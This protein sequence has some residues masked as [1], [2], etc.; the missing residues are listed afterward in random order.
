MGRQLD[1]GAGMTF[2]VQPI[3]MRSE[4]SIRPQ[5]VLS[6]LHFDGAHNSPLFSA[7]GVITNWPRVGGAHINASFGRFGQAGQFDGNGDFITSSGA[8]ASIKRMLSESWTLSM[9][10]RP[11]GFKAGGMRVFATGGGTVAYNATNGIQVLVQTLEV[12][13]TTR[14]RLDMLNSARNGANSITSTATLSTNVWT[15]IVAQQDVELGRLGVG[16]NGGIE[17]IDRPAVG[18]PSG[19]PS[20][21]FGTIPG[22]A[23]SSGTAY[24]GLMDE[25][26]ITIGV[27]QYSG[28]RYVLPSQ[29]FDIT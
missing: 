13:G 7:S 19:T 23:G 5:N 16:I 9:W 26:L 20:A 8:G 11:I 28:S 21:C 1:D 15:H 6:L 22:E 24:Q 25:A 17:Y 18:V 12:S 14:L 29:P 4:R 3:G 2:A 27:A 10:I